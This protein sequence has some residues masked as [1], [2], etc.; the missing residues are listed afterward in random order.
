MQ[1]KRVGILVGSTRKGSYSRSIAEYFMK[2]APEGL[3][4]E[5]IEIGHLPIYNQDLD[6]D[7]PKECVQFKDKVA[8]MDAIMFV[9]PEHNRS[10]PAVLKNAIDIGSRPY[11]TN[12]W[13]GKPAA[14]ISQSVGAISGFGANHHLRQV[15]TFLDLKVMAQ[16]EC[17]LANIANAVDENGN[18]SSESTEKFLDSVS[19]AFF[20]WINLILA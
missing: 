12:V 14:V 3:V 5:L 2:N 15:L 20:R 11:G 8:E 19:E 10:Y 4:M 9:T 1:Q 18:L 16:P 7:Y 17:Y 6:A 13:S